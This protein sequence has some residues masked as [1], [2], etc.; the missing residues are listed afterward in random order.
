MSHIKA[1]RLENPFRLPGISR[2]LILGVGLFFVIL[3][4]LL[5]LLSAVADWVLA[6][7]KATR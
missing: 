3:V 5:S 1:L 2:T 7:L 4:G 6:V